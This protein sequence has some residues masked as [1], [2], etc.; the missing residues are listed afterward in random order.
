MRFIPS[1]LITLSLL[2]STIHAAF[3]TVVDPSSGGLAVID[4]AR[5]Y[6]RVSYYDWGPGWS[7]VK[8][9][10]SVVE[11]EVGQ[12]AAWTIRASM[13]N[14]VGYRIDAIWSQPKKDCILLD[15]TLT[16]DGSSKLILSQFSLTMGRA[17]TNTDVQVVFF[18]G[19]KETFKVPFQRGKPGRGVSLIRFKDQ[20]G[21][22]TVVTFAT[23]VSIPSDR[24]DARIAIAQGQITAGKTET[25]K[26]TIDTRRDAS[27]YY[28]V[29]YD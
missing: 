22:E 29:S 5:P 19:R 9:Q 18:D 20:M 27:P 23:P 15:A 3:T 25:L 8:R 6:L 13:N 17:F 11:E 1:F 28:L 4:G 12:K 7:G 24:G 16:P 10:T 21:R 2:T 26:F 14:K